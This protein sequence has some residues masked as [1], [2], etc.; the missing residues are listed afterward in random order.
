MHKKMSR[1]RYMSVLH[2]GQAEVHLPAKLENKVITCSA[3]ESCS[4]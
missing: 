3:K 1:V 4:D 2:V